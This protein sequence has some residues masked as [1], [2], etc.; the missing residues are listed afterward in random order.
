MTKDMMAK[1]LSEF[2]VKHKKA[3]DLAEYKAFGN[4]VPVKD[5]MARRAFGSWTRVI[6]AV[7]KRYPIDFEALNTPVIA[8]KVEV[9]A[10]PKPKAA[11]KAKVEKKDV[12]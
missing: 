9:K 6:S 12:K 1:A 4:D 5:Y 10:E 11:P 8:P 2:F 7:M 3:L